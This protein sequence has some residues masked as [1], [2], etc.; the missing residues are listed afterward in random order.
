MRW[1]GGWEHGWTVWEDHRLAQQRIQNPS[2]SPDKQGL[3]YPICDEMQMQKTMHA[4]CMPMPRSRPRP[5]E[6]QGRMG[7]RTRTRARSPQLP[8]HR[9]LSLSLSCPSPHPLSFRRLAV[10]LGKASRGRAFI[11][12]SFCSGML[13]RH[14]LDGPLSC[15]NC[16]RT[17]FV[18]NGMKIVIILFA[19]WR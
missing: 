2:K 15:R 11:L 10:H 8:A 7:E 3:S 18:G 13:G 19:S 12:G 16:P 17:C 6:R 14:A 9:P 1:V 4:S 5:R